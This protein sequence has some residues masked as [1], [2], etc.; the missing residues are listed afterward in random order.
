[1]L[2]KNIY[3]WLKNLKNCE[4]RTWQNTIFLIN[5]C[6]ETFV[7]QKSNCD[8]SL[9]V[10]SFSFDNNCDKTKMV[11]KLKLEQNS[12]CNKTQIKRKLN[13]Q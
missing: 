2:L 12:N 3:K 1:M 5:F 8:N 11:T 10:F 4:K 13:L 9:V 6:Y 7:C